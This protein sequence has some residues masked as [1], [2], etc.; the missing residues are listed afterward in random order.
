MHEALLEI[1]ASVVVKFLVSN[2]DTRQGFEL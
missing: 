1:K 2:T